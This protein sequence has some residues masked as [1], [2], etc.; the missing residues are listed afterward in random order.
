PLSKSFF[1]K[2]PPSCSHH[3][4]TPVRFL[5]LFSTRTT[6]DLTIPP[7]F[8]CID[9]GIYLYSIANPSPKSMHFSLPFVLKAI[10]LSNLF[11]EQPRNKNKYDSLHEQTKKK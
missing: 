5:K 7:R 4:L 6:G 11:L 10:P 8:F 9:V 1:R 3:A 2:W